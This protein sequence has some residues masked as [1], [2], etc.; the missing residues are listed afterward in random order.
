MNTKLIIEAKSDFEIM[1]SKMMEK[2]AVCGKTME[3]VK[4][5]IE[6]PSLQQLEKET[7]V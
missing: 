4:K 1:F 5:N 7:A 2:N 6:T 3:T